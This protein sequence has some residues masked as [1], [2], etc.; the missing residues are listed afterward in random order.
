MASPIAAVVQRPAA[1]VRPVIRV[2]PRT[3]IIPPPKKPI[4]EMTCALKRIGSESIPKF[5]AAYIPTNTVMAAP[6][7]TRICVRIPAARPLV[8]RS[9]PI[10]P[11]STAASSSRTTAERIVFS[12]SIAM[13]PSIWCP[14]IRPQ[15]CVR[16]VLRLLHRS[17]NNATVFSFVLQTSG[18]NE[19]I[20][21]LYPF[22][23][24]ICRN[25][26]LCDIC[27]ICLRENDLN[28]LFFVDK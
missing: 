10:S 9:M 17:R 8:A 1:V 23:V 16:Y 2:R 25:V 13:V 21:V 11:P 6:T 15:Y 26:C 19:L 5:S 12:S 7:L 4:P 14:P 27:F 22:F 18:V 28:F 3:R 20:H 24:Y